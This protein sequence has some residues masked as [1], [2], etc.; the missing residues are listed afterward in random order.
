MTKKGDRAKERQHN[1]SEEKFITEAKHRGFQAYK[2]G[3]P[4]FLVVG[5]GAFYFVEV[6]SNNDKLSRFQEAT[7]ATLQRM[8]YEVLISKDGEWIEPS[9]LLNPQ[10]LFYLIETSRYFMNKLVWLKGECVSLMSQIDKETSRLDEVEEKL[11][12][13]KR[14]VDGYQSMKAEEEK[15]D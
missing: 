14:R 11:I 8:G 2:R 6:K 9:V 5:K 10:R 12:R 1:V 4:D 15:H 7:F 3:W 13:L